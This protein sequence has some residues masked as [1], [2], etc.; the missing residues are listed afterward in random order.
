MII[1]VIHNFIFFKVKEIIKFPHLHL[2]KHLKMI[3]LKRYLSYIKFILDHLKEKE[4]Y[5]Y[6]VTVFQI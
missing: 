3:K 2:R 1:K 6:T 4:C 5:K